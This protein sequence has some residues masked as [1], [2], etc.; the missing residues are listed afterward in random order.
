MLP[1]HNAYVRMATMME[2]LMSVFFVTIPVRNVL[3]TQ[4][5]LNVIWA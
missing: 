5:V 4:H 1:H 2:V 3:V